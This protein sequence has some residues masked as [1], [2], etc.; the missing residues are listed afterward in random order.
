MMER[1][2]AQPNDS[3]AWVA[4]G[5][6]LM[7]K[8]RESVDPH[9]SVDAE[10]S[11]RQALGLRPDFADAMTGMAWVTGT[12]HEFAQSIEWANK[13]IARNPQDN[14]A[15]G[16]LGDADVERGNY[17]AAFEHYQKMLDIRPDI[18]SYSRGAHLLFLSGD[19]RKALWLMNKAIRAGGPH[20][21]NT[22]WCRA[23]LAQMLWSTGALLPAEQVLSDALRSTP[24]NY[25]V[26]LM[27]GRVKEARKDY[28]AAQDF[29]EKAVAAS[30]QHDALVALGDL[31]LLTG[32]KQ[33]AEKQFARA[34]ET[35]QHLQSHGV[36]GEMHIARFLADHDRNLDK[37]L[38]IAEANKDTK[39]PADADV[40]AWVFY[41]NGRFAEAKQALKTAL[42]A[43][44]PDAQRLF[45]AG[46]IHAKLGEREPAQRYLQDALSLNPHFSSRNAATAAATLKQLG[47]VAGATSGS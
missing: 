32:Q 8:S 27:M 47:Q 35:H 21:E 38:Q 40:V 4:L 30:P 22:A 6:A 9:G 34:M 39:N 25:H 10:K 44:T 7:Q 1:L 31:L 29:Y 20:A 43:K 5:D 18:S 3:A 11:Y 2:K 33:A 28:Q 16:L 42:S 24:S 37:A 45:H 46:M 13:A 41:K 12:R 19:T 15:Y 23:Q 14:A 17:D 26:L 36:Q